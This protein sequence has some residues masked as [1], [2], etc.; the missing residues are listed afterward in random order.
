M[1]Q[2]SIFKYRN[3]LAIGQRYNP[4][5]CLLQLGSMINGSSVL[6]IAFT[7]IFFFCVGQYLLSDVSKSI[8][9]VEYLPFKVFLPTC[10]NITPT[11]GIK[12]DSK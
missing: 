7:I 4:V 3:I 12:V 9:R 1:N 10:R 2:I 11:I 5:L 6:V 8:M